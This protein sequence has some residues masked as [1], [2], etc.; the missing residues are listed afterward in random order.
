MINLV[1]IVRIVSTITSLAMEIKTVAEKE[2]WFASRRNLEEADPS[3]VTILRLLLPESKQEGKETKGDAKATAPGIPNDPT[4]FFQGTPFGDIENYTCAICLDVLTDP[5]QLGCGNGHLFCRVHVLDSDSK[6]KVQWCPGCNIVVKQWFEDAHVKRMLDNWTVRCFHTDAG[7]KETFVRRDNSKHISVCEAITFVCEFC[8][9]RFDKSGRAQ[10]SA[11]CPEMPTVCPKGCTGQDP[12]ILRKDLPL[13]ME[14][15]CAFGDV[16]CPVFG[17]KLG[18]VRRCDLKE[19]LDP[20]NA[21]IVEMHLS[22]IVYRHTGQFVPIPPIK[23]ASFLNKGGAYDVEFKRVEGAKSR[24]P[25]CTLETFWLPATYFGTN[26]SG[27]HVFY[28]FGCPTPDYVSKERIV[29]GQVA[30][31]LSRCL[32]TDNMAAMQCDLMY[33]YNSVKHLAGVRFGAWTCCDATW[34]SNVCKRNKSL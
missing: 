13:H 32:A 20:T 5:V 2:A 21:K 9:K 10:H 15:Q 23:D 34:D 8:K 30:P 29:L 26:N 3:D 25:S 19:H 4:R 14:K 16:E 12:S 33:A 1:S 11:I 27:V 24:L 7:C 18:S 31:A 22:G 6:L 28:I 17:C